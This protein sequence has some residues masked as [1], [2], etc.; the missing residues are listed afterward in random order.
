MAVLSAAGWLVMPAQTQGPDHA[1]ELARQ[2]C[3]DG[4]D[5][6]L[7]AGGDGTINQVANGL[8]TATHEGLPL[9]TLGLLP[10]G[11]ANVLARDLGLPVPGPGLMGTLP[12]AARLLLKSTPEWIDAGLASGPQ[13]KR[14]FVCWAGVGIDAAITA[15]VM[16]NP[17]AKRRFRA[18]YFARA[19]WHTC[20]RSEMRLTT[21]SASTIWSARA[22]AS[23]LWPATSNIMPC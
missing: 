6:V 2:A 15:H 21:P 7:V 5:V 19:R 12:T 14:T 4:Y 1:A 20:R 17:Q 9:A 16:A 18:L 22:R 23:W 10:A 3:V 11:T 8:I 13:G